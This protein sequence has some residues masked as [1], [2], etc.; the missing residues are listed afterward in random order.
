MK[1]LKASIFLWASPLFCQDPEKS[2]YEY[3]LLN[4][5]FQKRKIF[6]SII[7]FARSFCSGIKKL[8][9]GKIYKCEILEKFPKNNSSKI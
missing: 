3:S 6:Y 8:L 2:S 1:K 5:K 9:K 4:S 7:Y